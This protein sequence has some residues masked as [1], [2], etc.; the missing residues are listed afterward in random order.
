MIDFCVLGS[1]LSGSTIANLLSK[2]FSIQIIEKAKGVGGRSSNKKVGKR[3]SF[4]HGL[5][6][7]STIDNKFKEYLNNL[8]RKK[9]LKIWEGNHL[10]FTFKNKVNSKKVIGV[11][12]NNDINKYLLRNIKKNLGKEITNIKFKKTHWEI[13]DKNN[14]FK[15]KNIIIT[16]PFEQIK[17]LAKKYLSRN[18][19]NSRVK[20]SPNITLLLKQKNKIEIPISSIKLNN[21]KIISWI[22][23]ENSKKRFSSTDKYWTIQ[24]TDNYSKKIINKYKK[25]RN[26]YSKQ[27]AKEFSNILGFNYSNFKIFKIHGWKYSKNNICLDKKSY[28]DQKLRI[29]LCGDWFIGPKAESAWLSAY[30]LFEKIKKNPPKI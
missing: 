6:Y 15:A 20:M 18:F 30:S 3:I 27:I 23:N 5:Q 11:K 16:F 26:Y 10:D 14:K 9:I 7:Y 1:G 29:G 22:A 17:K 19:L 25:K 24:T 2:K 28:W 21:N 8:I 12:G 4:D 13:S